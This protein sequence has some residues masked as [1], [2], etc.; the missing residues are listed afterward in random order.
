MS[1]WSPTGLCVS[2]RTAGGLCAAQRAAR[3][4]RG[5]PGSTSDT[6]SEVVDGGLESGDDIVLNP[7]V[8]FDNGNF[9]GR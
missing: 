9:F 2:S 7:P 5:H 4:D 1:C 8:N 6:N 3:A